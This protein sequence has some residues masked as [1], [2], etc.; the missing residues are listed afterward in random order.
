[1]LQFLFSSIVIPNKISI[2]RIDN[3]LMVDKLNFLELEIFFWTDYSI[4][5]I[6]QIVLQIVTMKNDMYET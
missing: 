4:Y 1:M 6:I 5:N 2:N 3:Q